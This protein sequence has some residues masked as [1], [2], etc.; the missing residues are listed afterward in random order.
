MKR[1][2][3]LKHFTLLD[4]VLTR[5]IR[6]ETLAVDCQSFLPTI[7]F[8][9]KPSCRNSSFLPPPRRLTIMSLAAT[10]ARPPLDGSPRRLP[11]RLPTVS[12]GVCFIST[13][14]LRDASPA[15]TIARMPLRG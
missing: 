8:G 7:R 6:F 2:H 13:K 9:Y 4:I 1:F 15:W 10:M 12:N 11:S 14:A 3:T 5:H